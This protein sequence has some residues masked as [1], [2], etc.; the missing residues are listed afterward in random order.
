MFTC[1]CGQEIKNI[2][3]WPVHCRCRR[4]YRSDGTPAAPGKG[5]EAAEIKEPGIFTKAI[6]FCSEM[7]KWR[8]A[9]SPLRPQAEQEA[10]L[11]VCSECPHYDAKRVV[12]KACGCRLKAAVKMA[13]KTC[14]LL[15]WPS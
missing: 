4:V 5:V 1:E 9:G 2:R 11:A 3:V 12:C 8:A 14:P 13:T 10:A 6:S 7:A 15:K